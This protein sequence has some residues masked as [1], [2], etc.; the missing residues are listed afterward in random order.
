MN[1]MNELATEAAYA[2]H[3]ANMAHYWMRRA[4]QAEL[5]AAHLIIAAGGEIV[6][7]E[8]QLL[9]RD[10]VVESENRAYDMARVFRARLSNAP[11][12]PDV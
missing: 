4:Q 8:H 5:T 7:H 3:M 9:N 12:E 10:V 1:A 2:D 11:R 6:V